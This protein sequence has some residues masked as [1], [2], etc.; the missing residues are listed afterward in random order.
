LEGLL[1]S[2]LL[3]RTVSM[4]AISCTL[5]AALAQLS[6]RCPASSS[7]WPPIQQGA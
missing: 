3:H 1:G 7:L 2:A 6:D 5:A 4:N